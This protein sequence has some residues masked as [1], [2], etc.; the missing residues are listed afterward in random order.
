MKKLFILLLTIVLISI[1]LTTIV[2]L[3]F[4]KETPVSNDYFT[5]EDNLIFTYY[6]EIYLK[7]YISLN[8]SYLIDEKILIDTSKL[9]ESIFEFNYIYEDKE[10][11]GQFKYFV[12]DDTAPL[13]INSTNY[14]IEKGSEFS[15]QNI[16]CADNYDKRPICEVT[17]TYDINTPG[18]YNL[19]F[20]ATDSSNN[21]TEKNITLT[22]K[23]EI[24]PST[25]T[26]EPTP[27]YIEDIIEKHKT[28]STK[29]GV[30]V[31]KWQ[32]EID[33]EMLKDSGV[34]FAIIRIGYGWEENKL[35]E[36]FWTHFNG[37]KNAGLDVG[38]YFYS[39]ADSVDEAIMQ[40]NWVVD[41]LDGAKLD[42]PIS[43]DWEE[44]S[45]FNT[46]NISLTE[47]NLMAASFIDTVEKHGYIGMNYGS[48]SY[49]KNIWTL[50]DNLTWLAH[51]T[52]QTNYEND[53]YIWQLTHYGKVP[54]YD[55][56]IDLN[57]LYE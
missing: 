30:D 47:L 24:I 19:T 57:V 35:D 21:V 4:E 31:S 8:D 39:Y 41:T 14:T 33:W 9:G 38:V 23:E 32:E 15:Y 5:Q 11:I 3:N 1:P 42:L 13:V 7:D 50:N 22:V 52:S 17:G 54:G 49:L 56:F 25:S 18:V 46:Y 53:Y 16:F 40:A 43:Y 27:I 26:Y 6:Q 28:E 29:I 51:Y 34:E 20:V 36:Y 37:A 44:W 45:K 10:Y 12:I 48:A 2:Y 55:G